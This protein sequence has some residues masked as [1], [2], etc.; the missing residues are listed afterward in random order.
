MRNMSFALAVLCVL[1]LATSAKAVSFSIAGG[2]ADPKAVGATGTLDII[3]DIAPEGTKFTNGGIDLAITS[4]TPGVMKF[5]ANR[6]QRHEQFIPLGF[7]I[8]FQ[9]LKE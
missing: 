8:F 2:G 4:A 5:A 6:F 7:R 9:L 1:S 3:V